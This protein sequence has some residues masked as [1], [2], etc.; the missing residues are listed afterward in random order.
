MNKLI[1]YSSINHMGFFLF[2]I[3]VN[4][5]YGLFVYFLFYSMNLLFLFIFLMSILKNNDNELFNIYQF[6]FFKKI[7]YI[8]SIALSIC[9]LS[10]AGVPPLSGFFGKYFIVL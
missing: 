3:I 10:I 9:F 5:F 4:N 7:N 2:A 6:L 1:A 8:G